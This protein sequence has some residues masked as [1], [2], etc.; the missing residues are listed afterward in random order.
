MSMFND[1]D[2]NRAG[3]NDS[4]GLDVHMFEK[5]YMNVHVLSKEDKSAWC[6]W[7]AL[8]TQRTQDFTGKVAK[9]S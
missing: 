9:R 2:L 5:L 4:L 8:H 6:V 1:I 3:Q 7:E